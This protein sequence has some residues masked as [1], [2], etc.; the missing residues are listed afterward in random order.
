MMI[1]IAVAMVLFACGSQAATFSVTQRNGKYCFLRPDGRGLMLLGM[2]HAS[3][4]PPAVGLETTIKDLRDCKFNAVGNAKGLVDEFL[5][6]HNA[7]KLAGSP[8]VERNKKGT[9]KSSKSSYEDVFDPAVKDKL[10]KQIAGICQ[11][12]VGNPHCVGGWWTDIPTWGGAKAGAKNAFVDYFRNL[13][14]TAPGRIRYEQFLAQEGDH[15]D[16]AFLR[17]IARELYT[18][19]AS[20]YR[21]Y[22][23]GRLLFGERY[24]T[25]PGAPMEVI[26]EAGKVVDIISFQPYEKKLTG[27]VLDKIH[28]ITGKPIFLSDWN[29]SFKTDKYDKTMWPQF[30][31][32]AEAAISYKNYLLSAFAKP[33]I[34]GYFK[35]QYLDAEYQPGHLKQGLRKADK[36][37]YADWAKSISEIHQVLMDQFAKEGRWS[38]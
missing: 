34:L 9:E 27:E 13:P 3:A 28:A 35:C 4:G 8:K 14:K 23:P 18:Y 21:E 19:T 32:E 1:K 17:I 20:C 25:I 37:L 31:N 11:Q 24:N 29:Q 36:T 26:E 30:S 5:F 12:T 38:R 6:I 15:G 33:Y 22:A 10:R 7:D 16:A 2:S